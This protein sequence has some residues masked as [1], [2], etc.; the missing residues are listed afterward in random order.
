LKIH[1]GKWPTPSSLWGLEVIS[2]KKKKEKK[3][4]EQRTKKTEHALLFQQE[5]ANP[6]EEDSG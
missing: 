2:K 3:K 4:K 5:Y 1:E 6:G